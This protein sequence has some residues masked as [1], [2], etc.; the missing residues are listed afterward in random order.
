MINDSKLTEI[1]DIIKEVEEVGKN[2]SK[3]IEAFD[4][5]NANIREANS[6]IFQIPLPLLV[7]GHSIILECSEEQIYLTVANFY[8]LVLLLPCNI[9]KSEVKGYFDCSKRTLY[10]VM[11]VSVIYF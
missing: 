3:K 1:E 11:P 10:I 6:L 4:G 2:N 7:H 9:L 5:F 8:E